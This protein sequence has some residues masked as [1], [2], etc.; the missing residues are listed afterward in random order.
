MSYSPT[1]W[2]TGDTITEEKLNNMEDGINEA[3][4]PF[5]ITLTPTALDLSGTMN[6]TPAEI[7]EAYDAGRRIAFDIPSM[8]ATVIPHQFLLN[9]DDTIVVAGQIAYEISGQPVLI[10]LTTNSAEQTYITGIFP[11]APY[12]VNY[13]ITWERD[14]ELGVNRLILHASLDDV[15]AEHDVGNLVTATARFEDSDYMEYRFCRFYLCAIDDYNNTVTFY[16]HDPS[17]GGY[18][19]ISFYV[20][21]SGQTMSTDGGYVPST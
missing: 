5:V 21:V 13:T 14:S 18:D 11:L 4:N 15:L 20:D 19:P 1:T 3:A 10:S 8:D 2:Q 7:R 16:G 6:K 17:A 9:G 12:I